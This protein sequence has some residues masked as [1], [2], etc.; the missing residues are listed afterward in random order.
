M[1]Q[2]SSST[3][4]PINRELYQRYCPHFPPEIPDEGP[5]EAK[6]SGCGPAADS[7]VALESDATFSG[8]SARHSHTS[9]DLGNEAE[10]ILCKICYEGQE[11]E[12]GHKELVRPCA[13]RGSAAYIHIACLKQWH[14]SLGNPTTLRCPTC[15]QAYVGNVAV[16]LARM[17]LQV[18]EDIISSKLKDFKEQTKW[19]ELR[20][21][22]MTQLAQ[23]LSSQGKYAEALPLFQC[24]L[25][26]RKKLL[27]PARLEVAESLDAMAE[28]FRMQ[29]QY[30]EALRLKKRALHI[31][32]KV[33]GVDHPGTATSYNNLG[34]VLQSMDL[35]DEA[36][37]YFESAVDIYGKIYGKEHPNL[38]SLL[39]NLA[40]LLRNQG[41]YT[42]AE[43]LYQQ[44]LSIREKV[45]GP[46]HPIAA[47]SLNNLAIVLSDM[48]KLQE[49]ERM[50]KRCLRI[51]R[52]FYDCDHPEYLNYQGNYGIILKKM[53]Q[54]QKARD[55]MQQALDGL[56][57][58][59]FHAGHVWL[60][61]FSSHLQEISNDSSEPTPPTTV[62]Q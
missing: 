41:N 60:V 26:L 46:E 4:S 29:G 28:L 2:P 34:L 53:G 54:T 48:G 32:E 1:D 18:V 31:R 62:S 45:L 21:T 50:S 15:K 57:K 16:Q 42:E 44:S 11:D 27:G 20:A 3:R 59:E 38:A 55:C 24:S 33:L 9:S 7:Q 47:E 52:S 6:C 43:E 49:A 13:C 30:N 39:N 17:N 23:V 10:E 37:P 58:K 19:Q 40:G 8:R 12:E 36:K 14:L 56:Q 22:V 25:D 51:A 5:A 61:K 35:L